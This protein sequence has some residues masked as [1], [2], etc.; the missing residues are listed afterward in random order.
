MSSYMLP[1][2]LTA[3]AK[4]GFPAK[5][6]KSKMLILGFPPSGDGTVGVDTTYLRF[7]CDMGK[8]RLR[9]ATRGGSSVGWHIHDV[10]VDAATGYVDL[11]LR[12]GE[13]LASICRAP[14]DSTDQGD[15]PVTVFTWS[16]G[17]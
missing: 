17:A 3:N 1:G 5:L 11:P 12:V 13:C 7:G 10:T 2:G 9:V 14:L 16:K 4:L 8:A 6:D 15:T